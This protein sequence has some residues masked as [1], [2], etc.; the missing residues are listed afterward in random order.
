M[1]I[2]IARQPIFLATGVLYGYEFLFRNSEE[3]QFDF[4]MDGS[5]ATRSLLS[6]LLTEFKLDTLT[7]G[8]YAFVNFTRELLEK[9][10]PYLF[11]PTDFVIEILEDIKGDPVL[12]RKLSKLKADGYRLAL[13][14][15]TGD[16]AQDPIVELVDIIKVDFR[17]TTRAKQVQIARRFAS[18]KKLLAE[19]IETEEDLK[20][21]KKNQYSLFQGYYFSR[22]IMLSKKAAELANA[23]YVRLWKEIRKPEP[24]IGALAR[25]IRIDVNLSYKFLSR[26]NTLSFAGTRKVRTIEGALVHMGII[27]VRR[28]SFAI[29]MKDLTSDLGD[30]PA[31]RSL[32][33]ALFSQGVAQAA[34]L[35]EL[36]EDAYTVGIFSA[37]DMILGGGLEELLRNLNLS[38]AARDALLKGEGALGDILRFIKNYEIGS[39][40]SLSGFLQEYSL[41]DC[42][43]SSL[44]L[45]S[46]EEAERLFNID[47]AVKMNQAELA[48]LHARN[49]ENGLK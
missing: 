17:L 29:L 23:T 33:R 45:H 3:N 25:I 16:P 5:V 39:W 20:H 21:A 41:T 43:L 8:T 7:G 38:P 2:Y 9:D 15:Y 46:V 44:Y 27:E 42:K 13:D 4:Q 34:G 1:D 35:K 10:F 19:K 31:K 6:D 37:I 12:I 18:K 11:A 24:D 40:Q 32:V 49:I 48:A 14:D 26:A 22:P 36:Q 30:E 47:E 28:W